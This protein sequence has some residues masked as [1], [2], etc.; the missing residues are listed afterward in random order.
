MREVE[1]VIKGLNPSKFGPEQQEKLLDLIA[2]FTSTPRTDLKLTALTTGSVHAFV[3]MP[4]SA[5]YE[6]K[7]AALN[8]D[9]RLVKFGMHALRLVGDRNFVLL[10][11]GNVASL[12]GGKSGRPSWLIYGLALVIALFLSAIIISLVFPQA[13]TLLS[14][15]F[16]T[17]TPTPT[18]TFTSTPSY[19][20]TL[21]DTPTSTPSQTSTPTPTST[22]TLTPT[23]KIPTLKVCLGA[24]CATRTPTLRI[25]PF[26]P[27]LISICTI[28]P[29]GLPPPN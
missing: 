10:K 23:P 27:C 22:P 21:T 7:A 3:N 20:P 13:G 29:D 17:T 12:K 24:S 4:A 15:F 26:N 25:I 28:T 9:L 19:T 1:I 14:S 2:D 8:R 11:T 18:N 16:A 5:A 6:L